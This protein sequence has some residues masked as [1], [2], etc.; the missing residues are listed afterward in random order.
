MGA[1][2][3]QWKPLPNYV[4]TKDKELEEVEMEEIEECGD[5]EDRLEVALLRAGLKYGILKKVNQPKED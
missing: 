4:E 5:L 2:D 3:Y 1:F